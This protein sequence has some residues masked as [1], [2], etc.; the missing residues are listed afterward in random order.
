MKKKLSE[1]KTKTAKGISK[2]IVNMPFSDDIKEK[3]AEIFFKLNIDNPRAESRRKVIAYC[4]C[5]AHI[6]LGETYDIMEIAECTGLDQNEI[7]TIRT[8][9]SLRFKD[10]YTGNDPYIENIVL[11]KKYAAFDFD[12][13]KIPTLIE[14]YEKIIEYDSDLEEKPVLTLISAFLLFCMKLYNI[15]Y[16]KTVLSKRYGLTFNTINSYCT[17]IMNIYG[18]CGKLSK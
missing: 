4:L 18:K 6:N 12:E 13:Q 15:E 3:A 8:R 14:I 10:G 7:G 9:I 17:R 16:N 5:D 1:K 2:E 11:L